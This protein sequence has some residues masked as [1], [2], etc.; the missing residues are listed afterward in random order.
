MLLKLLEQRDDRDERIRSPFEARMLRVLRRIKTERFEVD[1]DVVIDGE[2]FVIDFFHPLSKIGIEC[3]SYKFHIGK[4]NEDARRD[5]KLAS[6][7]IELLYF[8]WADLSMNHHRVEEEIRAAIERKM[9][10][11][12]L[13]S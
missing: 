1:Y 6:T 9:G 4:H 3:H 12:K 8:T 11:R 10:V 2:R 5:R 13:F 7:G